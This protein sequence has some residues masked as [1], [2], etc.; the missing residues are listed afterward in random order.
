MVRP[1]GWGVPGARRGRLETD[2]GPLSAISDGTC[3]VFKLCAAGGY[4]ILVDIYIYIYIYKHYFQKE[5][6]TYT[7][8]NGMAKPKNEC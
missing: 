2:Y 1:R 7:T 6:H 5:A 4:C 3:C 8:I